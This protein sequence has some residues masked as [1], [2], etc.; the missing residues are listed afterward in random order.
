M[1][2][3]QLA[4]VFLL[5]LAMFVAAGLLWFFVVRVAA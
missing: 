2:N 3:Q 1:S 4:V 5:G